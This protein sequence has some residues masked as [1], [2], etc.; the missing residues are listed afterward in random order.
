MAV[1][2]DPIYS[3]KP[4][5]STDNATTV[6]SAVI[7]T[8]TADYT[9][10]SANHKLVWTAGTNGGY[11]ERLRF[12]AI[13]TNI[14]SVARIYINNGSIQ[15]TAAN[16]AFF[17]EI[18]LPPTTAINTTSTIDLDYPMGIAIDPSF[19]IYAGVGTTVASGWIVVGVGGQY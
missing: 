4:N 13:G 15:T 18:S 10:A 19:R 7:L 12:K 14:Q 5:V 2:I 3:T 6:S 11:I 16:N 8:A 9:G 1:N 17:G